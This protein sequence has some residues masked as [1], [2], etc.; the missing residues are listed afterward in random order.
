MTNLASLHLR[1]LSAYTIE[2]EEE[3]QK[4]G[5]AAKIPL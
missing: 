3:E 2:E 4:R 1:I 5:K